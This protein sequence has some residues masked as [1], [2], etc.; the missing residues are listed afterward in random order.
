MATDT[1][2]HRRCLYRF[3]RK[4][5]AIGRGLLGRQGVGH[6]AANR[7]DYLQHGD[8]SALARLPQRQ[9]GR[10]AAVRPRSRRAAGVGDV[11]GERE[12]H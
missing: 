3:G 10:G 9:A 11:A 2:T 8:V 7:L 5:A 12:D 4:A 1:A 6:H